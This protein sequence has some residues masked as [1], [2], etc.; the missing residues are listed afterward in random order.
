M[1][2][3]SHS[4]QE[5]SPACPHFHTLGTFTPLIQSFIPMNKATSSV[6][7]QMAVKCSR[8]E[9]LNASCY[10][11]C[12][13]LNLAKQWCPNQTLCSK[14]K[15]FT[16]NS[17]NYLSSLFPSWG[18]YLRE[19]INYHSKKENS[20]GKQA[21]IYSPAETHKQIKSHNKQKKKYDGSPVVGK[22]GN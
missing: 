7:T 15:A 13:L 6:K 9:V 11:R 18:I 20:D 14:A 19:V 10:E 4:E 2:V 12:L 3:K 5:N 17:S 16:E 21:H 22:D 8:P 1:S